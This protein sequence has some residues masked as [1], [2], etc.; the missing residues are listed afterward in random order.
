[1]KRVVCGCLLL[2]LLFSAGCAKE[3]L[4]TAAVTRNFPSSTTSVYAAQD[5]ESRVLAKY[6]PGQKLVV[7]DVFPNYLEISINGGVGY[8]LRHRVD[9]VVAIDPVNTPPYGVEVNRYFTTLENTVDVRQAPDESAASLITL[10]A[11]AKLSFIDVENGWARLIFKRQYGYVDTRLLSGLQMTAP[12]PE[13]GA[14]GIPIAVYTSFYSLSTDPLNLGRIENL[15]LCCKRMS[16]VMQPGDI[17]DFNNSVGPFEKSLGFQQAPVL[18][19][20]E[21]TPGYGG[22]SCQVSSTLYNVVLQ[23]TGVNV[24]Q[25]RPHGS[26][27]AKYLPH[28]VDASSGDLNF[29]IRNDFAFPVE[30]DAHVQD[31]ALFIA[32]YKA[33]AL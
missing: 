22:G 5:T 2:C 31:G 8:V 23:L 14:D 29:I 28:G 24:L 7:T 27:G 1:M 3:A 25:R 15:K 19:D 16:R 26:N 12:A 10:T 6:K 13:Y 30:I 17:L 32:F 4:Y 11:G 20:G 18:I 21:A 9:N 33:D